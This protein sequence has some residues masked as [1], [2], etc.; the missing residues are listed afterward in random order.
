[1][2]P[3]LPRHPFQGRTA[4]HSVPVDR[5]TRGLKPIQGKLNRLKVPFFL[6][7][8]AYPDRMGSTQCVRVRERQHQPESVGGISGKLA[9][10]HTPAGNMERTFPQLLRPR[11][12]LGYQTPDPWYSHREPVCTLNIR[13][14][15]PE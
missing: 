1:M 14:P 2:A 4:R 3:S 12:C 10:R 5:P 6:V 7:P 15:F 8:K 11:F 9:P 13:R